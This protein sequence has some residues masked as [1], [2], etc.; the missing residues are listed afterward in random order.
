VRGAQIAVEDRRNDSVLVYVNGE[1]VPRDQATVSV[2]DSGFLMG[3]GIW[4]SFR[5]V[6]GRLAFAE[7]HVSRLLAGARA[8]ALDIGLAADEVLKAVYKTVDA[9]GMVDGVHIRLMIT[10][11]TKR[12]P[13]QDP[14]LAIGK[15]TIVIVAEHRMPS[16]LQTGMSLFTA[17][18]RCPSQDV[19]DM[20]LNSHSRLHL[21]LALMQALNAGAD[22]AL[23]LDQHGFV[24]SC[25][26]TNFFIVRAG[27]L[28]T[29]TGLCSFNGITRGNVIALARANGMDAFERDFSLHDVYTA[30]EAFLT[31]TFGGVTPVTS[32]DGRKIGDGAPGDITRRVAALY[33]ALLASEAYSDRP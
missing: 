33:S 20:R 17:T 11:G 12:A 6:G 26:S 19:L 3:D 31:G 9:N 14:R 23:M 2:F 4:E 29:S 10:R 1:L 13:N 30:D 24:A 15:P 5:L 32:V 21:I 27:G 7:A 28:W 18:L 8:V 25:N 16:P 22:E